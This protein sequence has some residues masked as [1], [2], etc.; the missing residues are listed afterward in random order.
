MMLRPSR[1]PSSRVEVNPRRPFGLR[2]LDRDIRII[3]QRLHPKP[4][5]FS[6]GFVAVMQRSVSPLLANPRAPKRVQPANWPLSIDDRCLGLF[7]N[8]PR[9]SSARTPHSPLPQSRA[10]DSY[11]KSNRR[12]TL[13]LAR[14]R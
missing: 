13:P 7:G 2:V 6:I 1:K 11:A 4:Y 14:V 5:L 8:S 12:R 3:G 10:A 9:A